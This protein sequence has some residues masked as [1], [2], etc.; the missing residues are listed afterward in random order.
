MTQPNQSISRI[1]EQTLSKSTSHSSM[2]KYHSRST[3]QS[4][5]IHTC[6]TSKARKALS[7]H[8]LDL[9]SHFTIMTADTAEAEPIQPSVPARRKAQVGANEITAMV[10]QTDGLPG[11]LSEGMRELR[12]QMDEL[13]KGIDELRRYLDN[14]GR[15]DKLTKEVRAW[16]PAQISTRRV[17]G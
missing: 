6:L 3:E 16:D 17:A 8:L 2:Y 7:N 10:Q 15:L 14:N 12:R 13:R 1:E 5:S 11:E 9:P 4:I